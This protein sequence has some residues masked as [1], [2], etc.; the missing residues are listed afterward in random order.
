MNRRNVFSIRLDKEFG[1]SDGWQKKRGHWM[2][3]LALVQLVEQRNLH[4]KIYQSINLTVMTE[5]FS[6]PNQ[7]TGIFLEL[8]H[9]GPH[10]KLMESFVHTGHCL[11]CI[12]LVP[13][14]SEINIKDSKSLVFEGSCFPLVKNVT[15]Y[16]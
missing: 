1:L 5:Q 2:L 16:T 15:F 7:Q 11:N 10:S 9:P 6:T 13:A 14:H 12:N 4:A 8:Q 3:N